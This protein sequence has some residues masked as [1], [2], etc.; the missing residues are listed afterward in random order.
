MNVQDQSVKVVIH[1]VSLSATLGSEMQLI[2]TVYIHGQEFRVQAPSAASGPAIEWLGHASVVYTNYQGIGPGDSEAPSPLRDLALNEVKRRLEESV[3]ATASG[4]FYHVRLHAL[5]GPAIELKFDLSRSDLETRVLK[6][7]QAREPI[8]LTGRTMAIEK[9]ARLEVYESPYPSSKFPPLTA[10]VARQGTADWHEGVHGLRDVTDQLVT[11]PSVS[12][13]PKKLDA[14]K[15]LCVRFHAVVK[16]LRK[17][18]QG[19]S[20]LD[21]KD[22]YDVQDLLHAVLRIFFDDVRPEE[23]TPSFAGKSSRM[24][25]LLPKEKT[26]VETKMARPNLTAGELGTE[27]IDDVAR[28]KSHPSC[29]R[30]VCF[31]Y[32]PDG[33]IAN[34]AGIEADLSRPMDALDVVVIIMPGG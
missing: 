22:E 34:P 4:P 18:H 33:Y 3:E 23:W 9:L 31:V 2:A 5:E 32:D 8:V 21:V 30:L 25:F 13:I 28:Y 19:R 20:T 10:H 14:I 24:D 27:L 16:Q 29:K 11:T 7:Y 12:A 26:V 1:R 15:L 17:R 6:P